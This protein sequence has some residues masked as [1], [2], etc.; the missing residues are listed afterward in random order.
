MPGFSKQTAGRQRYR[1]VKVSFGGE[2]TAS[3]YQSS[4]LFFLPRPPLP[5]EVFIERYGRA[6]TIMTSSKHVDE[7]MGAA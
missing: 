6:S 7:W 2:I 5:L 1:D 3:T 4:L